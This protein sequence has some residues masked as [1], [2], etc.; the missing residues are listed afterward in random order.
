MLKKTAKFN[1]NSLTLF[2]D[3][4]SMNSLARV[5]NYPLGVHERDSY[6][7]EADTPTPKK[8]IREIIV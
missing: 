2:S 6:Q 4:H 5:K 3:G 7:E 1:F 8:V